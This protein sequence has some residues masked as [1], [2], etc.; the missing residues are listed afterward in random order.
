MV[1]DFLKEMNIKVVT[2]YIPGGMKKMKR[3]YGKYGKLDFY[4]PEFNI[5]WELDG[6][7]HNMQHA[8]F[9]K[10]PLFKLLL[11]TLNKIF[12]LLICIYIPLS[13]LKSPDFKIENKKS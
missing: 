1:L 6:Q 13:S 7:Q 5:I 8:F 2:Q 9:G 12:L 11:S 4:L 10:T 3:N